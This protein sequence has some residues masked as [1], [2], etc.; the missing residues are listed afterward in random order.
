MEKDAGFELKALNV[1]E[2]ASTNNLWMQFQADIFNAPVERPKVIE[3]IALEQL[4][5]LVWQ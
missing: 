5:K 1:D 3:T 2:G 4:N